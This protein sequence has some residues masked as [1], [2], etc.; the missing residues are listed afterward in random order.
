MLRRLQMRGAARPGSYQNQWKGAAISRPKPRRNRSNTSPDAN[1]TIPAETPTIPVTLIIR[2]ILIPLS[3]IADLLTPLF[4]HLVGTGQ[5]CLWTRETAPRGSR[6]RAHKP[7]PRL[8]R[9]HRER[10]A[11]APPSAASNSRRPMV[12]FIR[13]SRARC[14]KATI[15]RH[16]R[17]VLTARHPA[18]ASRAPRL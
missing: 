16:E 6:L 5:E 7:E 15:S 1:K 3:A 11:V 17:A 4:D 18:R 12:T 8:L 9:P 10:H 13:P 14:V 2:P